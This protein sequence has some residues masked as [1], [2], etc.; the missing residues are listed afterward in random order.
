MPTLI[1]N[2]SNGYYGVYELGGYWCCLGFKGTFA[3]PEEAAVYFDVWNIINNKGY[4]I[5]F[6]EIDV[7]MAINKERGKLLAEAIDRELVY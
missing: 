2:P 1:R 4:P 6:L 5:N 7:I 3:D